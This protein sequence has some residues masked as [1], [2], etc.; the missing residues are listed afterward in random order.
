MLQKAGDPPTHAPS[1][2]YLNSSPPLPLPQTHT[3]SLRILAALFVDL[4]LTTSGAN[5][6]FIIALQLSRGSLTTA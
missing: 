5:S 6:P 1:S 4:A 3:S 2:P